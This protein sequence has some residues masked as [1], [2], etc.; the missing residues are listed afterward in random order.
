MGLN[1]A[2]KTQLADPTGGAGVE[3]LIF[4]IGGLLSQVRRTKGT[5]GALRG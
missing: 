3:V 1:W 4:L 2:I 5:S